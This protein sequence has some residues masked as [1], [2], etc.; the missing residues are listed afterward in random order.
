MWQALKWCNEREL[1]PRSLASLGVVGSVG[2][3]RDGFV[4][5]FFATSQGDFA[6]LLFI[7]VD[8][9]LLPRMWRD[10]SGRSS[11]ALQSGRSDASECLGG[12][13][14]VAWDPTRQ[15]GRAQSSLSRNVRLWSFSMAP[16][17]GLVPRGNDRTF[18]D[19]PECS[20]I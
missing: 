10:E 7:H 5:R 14:F 17:D 4:S 20:S 12:F 16:L 18:L 13:G 19:T 1:G 11:G 8:G 9:D 6:D 3:G 15:L 2:L